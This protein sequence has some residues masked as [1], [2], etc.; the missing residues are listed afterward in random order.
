[1]D[2]LWDVRHAASYLGLSTRTV[3]QMARDGRIP[4]VRIGGRWRFRPPDL[5]SW[6]RNQARGPALGAH[7]DPHVAPLGTRRPDS[8]STSDELADLLSPITDP[9]KRRLAF[10]ARL[11]RECLARGWLPPV[12]V[13][14]QAVEFYSA[15]GYTT[16]DI[17]LVTA[18]EPLDEI[19]ARWGFE[20]RGRHWTQ[21]DLGL[22]VEAPGGRLA[23][24]QRERLTEVA[25]AGERAYVLGLEDVIVDR[26][27]ACVH[28]SSADDC[29]WAE[30]LIG[31]HRA[32]LDGE[33]LQRWADENGVREQLDRILEG[34]S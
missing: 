33:Y 26:L 29:R 18:S 31:A 30:V 2:E 28:W 9:L 13:G 12:I 5:D 24:G 14:G 21:S 16:V 8:L 20:Q 6:L 7:G 15:G 34:R 22:V 11:T 32:D 10:V 4:C 23:P 19:L 25:V 17:D 27:A 1:M 3:Y